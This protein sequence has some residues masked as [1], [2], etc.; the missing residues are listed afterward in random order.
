M[1]AT[2]IDQLRKPHPEQTRVDLEAAALLRATAWQV[3]AF[4][5]GKRATH[6]VHRVR[7]AKTPKA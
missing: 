5:Q 2:P 1:K 4:S 6:T 3:A 7:T